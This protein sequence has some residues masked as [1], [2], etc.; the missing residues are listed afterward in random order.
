MKALD[1]GKDIISQQTDIDQ[2]YLYTKDPYK[3]K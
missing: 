2:I 3:V 1:P